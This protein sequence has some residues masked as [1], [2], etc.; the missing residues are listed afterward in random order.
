MQSCGENE[1][2]IMPRWLETFILE[3]EYMEILNEFHTQPTELSDVARYSWVTE[4]LHA[5]RILQTP[6]DVYIQNR[7]Q[8]GFDEVENTANEIIWETSHLKLARADELAV[9]DAL[10]RTEQNG[11]NIESPNIST[12]RMGR[13]SPTTESD[14]VIFMGFTAPS[15]E[16]VFEMSKNAIEI[17]LHLLE[18][19]AVE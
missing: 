8:A 18:T 11:E 12:P 19:D 17:F 7:I 5:I 9:W 3:E 6:Y 10:F 2:P 14:D 15:T 1:T 13:K 4:T 16:N